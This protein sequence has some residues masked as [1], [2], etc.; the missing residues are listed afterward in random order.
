V[1]GI[2]ATGPEMIR[3]NGRLSIGFE[4]Y[5]AWVRRNIHT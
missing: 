1:L 2:V 3:V 5:R 4:E